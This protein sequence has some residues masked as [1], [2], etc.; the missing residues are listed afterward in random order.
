[1]T[2]SEAAPSVSPQARLVQDYFVKYTVGWYIADW[3]S[4]HIN[5]GLFD[6]EIDP[7]SDPDQGHAFALDGAL[8][9]LI[10][11]VTAPADIRAGQHVA[12]AGC[13]IGGAA[14]HLARKRGCRVTGVNVS[15]HQIDIARQKTQQAGLEHLVDFRL[16]DCSIR[17]PFPDASVDAVVN[18]ESA[19]H[20]DD[21][22]Q[23]LNEVRRILKPG[24]YL[25]A[26]DW[27]MTEHTTSEQ[28]KKYIEPVCSTWALPDLETRSSYVRMLRQADLET[29][30]LEGFAHDIESSF[31]IAHA[32]RRI[33]QRLVC[34]AITK[35]ELDR[36]KALSSLH[37]AW[38]QGYF[39][40]ARYCAR[41]IDIGHIQT[42]M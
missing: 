23:F 25:V 38:T 10:D 36:L 34:E 32:A 5:L 20:Y 8:T 22:Q 29:E 13:G 35:D 17:L 30:G 6:P 37:L 2:L 19:C 41:R 42:K 1:M 26:V 39:E 16:G 40:R 24:G 21:R 7:L 11:V 12:D 4:E 33:F 3:S 27:L 28:R 15:Q 31:L 18:I 14:R 9:R